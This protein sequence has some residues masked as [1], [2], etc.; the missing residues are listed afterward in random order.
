[1]IDVFEEYG[2]WYFVG[3][4][5]VATVILSGLLIFAFNTQDEMGG[6]G[7]AFNAMAHSVHDRNQRL[8]TV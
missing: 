7:R 6:L 8:E 2:F 1:M 4:F 3:G 5:L